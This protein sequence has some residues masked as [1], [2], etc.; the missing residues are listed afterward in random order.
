MLYDYHKYF[1]NYL[2]HLYGGSYK[3]Q[4]HILFIH[5]GKDTFRVSLLDGSRFDKFTFYHKNHKFDTDYWHKQFDCHDLEYG[6]YRC[7]THDFNTT[8]DIPF[9][10]EDWCRFEK[11]VLKYKLLNI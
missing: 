10:K 6:L 7:F 4:G 2:I 11:D 8:Y 5:C 3:V 1:L 9:N